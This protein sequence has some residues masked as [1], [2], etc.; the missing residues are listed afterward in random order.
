M[1]YLKDISKGKSGTYLFGRTFVSSRGRLLEQKK[2]E[3]DI[4]KK[5]INETFSISDTIKSFVANALKTSIRS[6]TSLSPLYVKPVDDPLFQFKLLC[7]NGLKDKN[8]LIVGTAT[9]YSPFEVYNNKDQRLSKNFQQV[10]D[11]RL[12]VTLLLVDRWCELRTY[13]GIYARY[14]P[15]SSSAM[16]RGTKVHED[17]EILTHPNV[18]IDIILEQYKDISEEDEYAVEISK[19]ISRLAY[20]FTA[21]SAREIKVHSLV[22]IKSKKFIDNSNEICN[23]NNSGILDSDNIVVSGVIDGLCFENQTKFFEENDNFNMSLNQQVT[24]F[25]SLLKFVEM[26]KESIYK[27]NLVISDVKVRFNNVLPSQESVIQSAIKQVSIYQR[28]LECLT[29][30]QNVTLAI[31]SNA[32]KRYN[33][34]LDKE[35]HPIVALR[36]MLENNYFIDDFKN[37]MNNEFPH[38]GEV[39]PI[40]QQE[41]SYNFDNVIEFVKQKNENNSELERQSNKSSFES[42]ERILKAFQRKDPMTKLDFQKPITL[43]YF[44]FRYSTFLLALKDTFSNKALVEYYSS[45]RNEK[46]AEVMEEYNKASI[47]SIIKDYMEFWLGERSPRPFEPTFKNFNLK[48]GYCEFRNVCD[49]RKYYNK[50]II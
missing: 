13:Y 46:F 39:G 38:D 28:I 36:I 17:L 33:L 3:N 30:S 14:K 18:D 37:W 6:N 44:L 4:L 25:D 5:D 48:C 15:K 20:L 26:N 10:V 7:E 35:I 40:K 31:I 43:R 16:K 12:S 29:V 9:D 27:G 22:N 8:Q 32:A 23:L 2:T 1:K 45:G 50:K 11:K 42:F 19:N 41:K 47:D 49:Y 21:G 24:D 34:D